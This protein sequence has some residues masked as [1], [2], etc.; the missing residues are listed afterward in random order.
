MSDGCA[1]PPL[2]KGGG[3]AWPVANSQNKEQAGIN[4]PIS[5]SPHHKGKPSFRRSASERY[6]CRSA[7]R[8]A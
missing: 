8:L 7:A 5:A 3:P 6:L 2:K 1:K 4:F